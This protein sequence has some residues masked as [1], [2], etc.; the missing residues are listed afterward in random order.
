M[1]LKNQNNTHQC[2]GSRVFQPAHLK[3]SIYA[4]EF[5]AVHFALDSFAHI[6]WGAE[7]P[8]L[9]LTDNKSLTRFFQA[10]RVPAALWNAVDHVL[11]FLFMLGH[12]PGRANLAADYLSRLPIEADR[13]MSLLL[14]DRIPTHET[15]V[16]LSAKTPDEQIEYF[17]T[18]TDGNYSEGLES[19]DSHLNHDDDFH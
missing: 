11:S 16:D 17:G 7:K 14:K 12:I 8:I 9:I 5:L 2:F 6:I 15:E 1:T 4:K 18:D 13:K 10:K 3:L 19:E